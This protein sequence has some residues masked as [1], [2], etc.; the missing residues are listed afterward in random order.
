MV[1]C[2]EFPFDPVP[3]SAVAARGFITQT[4]R[5]WNHAESLTDA[6]IVGYELVVNA[7]QHAGTPRDWPTP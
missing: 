7:I 1:D 2:E 4:L 5:R 3:D 6:L